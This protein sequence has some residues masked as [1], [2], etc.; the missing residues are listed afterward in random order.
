MVRYV[1]A[2]DVHRRERMQQKRLSVAL[3]DLRSYFGATTARGGARKSCGGTTDR[4]V[5]Q[6]NIAAEGEAGEPGG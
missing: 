2:A 4:V 1:K 3:R 5:G 6:P